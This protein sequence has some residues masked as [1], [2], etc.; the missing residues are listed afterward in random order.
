[1]GSAP[2]SG[3]LRGGL[4]AA[5]GGKRSVYAT[6]EDTVGVGAVRPRFHAAYQRMDDDL[7]D[8]HD[9]A[10]LRVRLGELGALRLV[11]VALG[12]RLGSLGDL[13]GGAGRGAPGESGAARGR[14]RE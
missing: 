1:M 11:P 5:D 7:L 12:A 9:R 13:A 6:D 4:R 3:L 2:V 8:R 10:E 14:P